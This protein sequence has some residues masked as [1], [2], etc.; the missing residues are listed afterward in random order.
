MSADSENAVAQYNYGL[1][2]MNGKGVDKD[3]KLGVLYL[4]KKKRRFRKFKRTVLHVILFFF[5]LNFEDNYISLFTFVVYKC[6]Y[7]LLTVFFFQLKGHQKQP[8]SFLTGA[9]RSQLVLKLFLI[10]LHIFKQ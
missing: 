6:R 8:I 10:E 2:L 1:H 9:D 5:K 7:L 3:P 4:K